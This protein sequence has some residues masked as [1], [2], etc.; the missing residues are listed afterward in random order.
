MTDIT[1]T[2]NDGN[3]DILNVC[4]NIKLQPDSYT[5]LQSKCVLGGEERATQAYI[6]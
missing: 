2:V 6:N 5:E 4:Q 3:Q 1:I